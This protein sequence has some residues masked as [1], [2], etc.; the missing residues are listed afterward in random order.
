MVTVLSPFYLKTKLLGVC[1]VRYQVFLVM[2]EGSL[3]GTAKILI[4]IVVYP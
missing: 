2:Q 1:S 3:L 4:Y